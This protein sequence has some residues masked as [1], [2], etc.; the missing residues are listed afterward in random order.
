MVEYDTE[1][2]GYSFSTQLFSLTDRTQRDEFSPSRHLCSS[3]ST[4]LY[5]LECEPWFYL[6]AS[7]SIARVDTDLARFFSRTDM[8][9][10][11]QHQPS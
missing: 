2:T 10:K 11:T 7:S 9:K 1:D 3:L 4:L 5:D 8:S 6:P